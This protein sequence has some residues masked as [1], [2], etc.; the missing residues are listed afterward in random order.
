MSGPYEKLL[1]AER[2]KHE[3]DAFSAKHP[4]MPREKRAKLFVPFD[5][6]TGYN[7]AL[8]EQEIVYRERAELSETRRQELDE[9]L[10]HLWWLYCERKRGCRYAGGSEPVGTFSPP[11]ATV[12]YFE[13]A[14]EQ[15]G[16]GL[17]HTVTGSVVKVD[18][19]QKY[20]LLRISDFRTVRVALRDVYG[21][22]PADPEHQD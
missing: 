2:P 15:D 14:P 5:A 22:A 11:T 12:T 17:Y 20:L 13:E 1:A 8:G 18:L 16:R 21:I 9:D 7:E 6:L 19:A 3:Q 10:R 4:P